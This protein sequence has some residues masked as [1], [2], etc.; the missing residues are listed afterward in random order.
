MP[1]YSP[2][3]FCG[4]TD[5]K[6]SRE[7]VLAQWISREFPGKAVW[8]I[9]NIV[10]GVSFK[11]SHIRLI[12]RKPCTRCNTGWM[13][14]L[15]SAAKP[16]LV[17][18]MKGE[19][20]TLT[21]DDQLLIA[22]WFAKTVII[23]E[24]LDK[25]PY[26]FQ[27]YERKALESSLDLPAPTLFFL[28]Q[29]AGPKPVTT[30]AIHIPLIAGQNSERA[31]PVDGYAATFTIKQ[32]AMQLFSLRVSPEL[33]FENVSLFLPGNLSDMAVQIWPVIDPALR[34]PPPY[35]L[36]DDDSLDFFK[37]RWTVLNEGP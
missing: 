18:L 19:R 34:W 24:F 12:S 14:Q 23:H 10:T 20:V 22:R 11:A 15:E 32:L 6:P 36:G 35:F 37:T 2:C 16:I 33:P 4:K 29:Y 1:T 31:T 25:G 13:R 27:P 8:D 7:H 21:P 28:A 30:H 9:E 5:S 26:F 17:P 3:I